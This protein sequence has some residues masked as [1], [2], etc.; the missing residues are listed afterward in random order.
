MEDREQSQEQYQP[1]TGQI[2]PVEEKKKKKF[3]MKHIS[4]VVNAVLIV[5]IVVIILLYNNKVDRMAAEEDNRFIVLMKIDDLHK[6]L[7]DT[8]PIYGINENNYPYAFF[9]KEVKEGDAVADVNRKLGLAKAE[10]TI[11]EK[12]NEIRYE[13]EFHRNGKHTVVI[14]VPVKD[15][16]VTGEPRWEKK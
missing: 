4:L 15:G 6:K 7:G 1:P 8:S 3:L 11:Q 14:I 10:A 12:D 5:A 2:G 9:W 16:K 13:F